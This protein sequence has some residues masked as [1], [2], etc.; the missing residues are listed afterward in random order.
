MSL[1]VRIFHIGKRKSHVVYGPDD[2]EGEDIPEGMEALREMTLKSMGK[3]NWATT[4]PTVAVRKKS[5][6]LTTNEIQPGQGRGE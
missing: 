6:T 3:T 5:G 4:P 1:V 2:P